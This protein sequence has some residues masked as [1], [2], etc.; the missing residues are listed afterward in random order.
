MQLR[1]YAE[2]YAEALKNTSKKEVLFS[3]ELFQQF[4]S[5]KQIDLSKLTEQNCCSFLAFLRQR[6]GIKDSSGRNGYA[7]RS[8]RRHLITVKAVCRYLEIKDQVWNRALRLCPVSKIPEKRT[9]K[10]LSSSELKA[11]IAALPATRSG[12]MLASFLGLFFGGGL[13]SQE[14]LNLKIADIEIK[15][16]RLICNLA[17]T[18]DGR[19]HRQVIAPQF[20]RHIAKIVS[21]RSGEGAKSNDYLL[22]NERGNQ[23]ARRALNKRLE[24]WAM[25]TLGRSISTHIGRYTAIT[26]LLEDGKTY[27][28]VQEFSRHKS[29][30]MVEIYDKREFSEDDHPALDLKY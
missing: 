16:D 10:K 2:Q 29:V 11:L 30:E 1:E 20:V 22:T 18:K 23:Y 3:C 19:S 27:R 14:A 28:E 26:K 4:L 13:R 7:N 21:I 25:K 9:I 24:Y 15:G 12:Y 6:K 17:N 5:L 8:A